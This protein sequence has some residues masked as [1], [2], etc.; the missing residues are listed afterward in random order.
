MEDDV[1]GEDGRDI[2]IS[3]SSSRSTRKCIRASPSCS[4]STSS[5][6]GAAK[7]IAGP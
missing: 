2:E 3:S 6:A 7:T 4:A 5:A 1:R